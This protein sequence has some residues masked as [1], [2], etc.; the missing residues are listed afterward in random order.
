VALQNAGQQPL[1]GRFNVRSPN[2]KLLPDVVFHHFSYVRDDESELRSKFENTSSQESTPSD[3]TWWDRVWP[4]L[5]DGKNIHMTPGSESC[6]ARMIRVTPS[7]LPS[8]MIQLG[9]RDTITDR[10]DTR[11]KGRLH[12]TSPANA[13]IP[14]PTAEDRAIYEDHLLR[15][16]G[17]AKLDAPLLHARMKTTYL[18]AMWLAE[19]AWG[20]PPG[21]R[22]LEIGCGSGGSTA[23]LAG[24]S[25]N[26]NVTIET[27]D[28]FLA[29]DEQTHAG[30]AR[31]VCEG[32][33]AEFFD[34]AA[35]L[36]YSH[37]LNHRAMSS[38]DVDDHLVG[39]FDLIFV[40]GN[41]SA[42]FVKNDLWLSWSRLKPGGLLV[43]HDYTTRFPDVIQEADA[44]SPDF[45]TPDGTSL[46]VRRKGI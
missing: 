9:W 4:H 31:G 22:I 40:D 18:E 2:T 23:V 43:L 35:R 30:V 13:L 6:W 39:T 17:H 16:T 28:P 42:E 21:G 24:A 8:A 32:N 38:E 25:R 19:F 3:P 1:E 44:F 34:T 27:V 26:L 14:I 37:R 12:G 33:Q 29:Y 11:W 15:I 46:A 41:H 5:P 36:R 45:A 7:M 10:L 20:I